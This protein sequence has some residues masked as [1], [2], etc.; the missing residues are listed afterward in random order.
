[1]DGLELS[2]LCW[3]TSEWSMLLTQI[4]DAHLQSSPRKC[5]EKVFYFLLDKHRKKRLEDFNEPSRP[6]KQDRDRKSG[7]QVPPTL[8]S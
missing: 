4:R 1:M 8:R 6:S 7:S 2:I 5:Y 3:A